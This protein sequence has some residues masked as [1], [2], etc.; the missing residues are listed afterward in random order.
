VAIG[1]TKKGAAQPKGAPRDAK[2]PPHDSKG[3]DGGRGRPCSITLQHLEAVRY[4]DGWEIASVRVKKRGVSAMYGPSIRPKHRRM[5][6]GPNTSALRA[7]YA[8]RD[9]PFSVRII[10]ECFEVLRGLMEH[11]RTPAVLIDRAEAR[12]VRGSG[13]AA[14]AP[15]AAD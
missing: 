10:G 13:S 4:P 11:G 15:W 9:R 8:R 7:F 6:T 2:R 1:K 14:A 3:G 5:G 12:G